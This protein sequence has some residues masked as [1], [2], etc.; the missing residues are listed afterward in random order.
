MIVTL[1]ARGACVSTGDAVTRVP[2]FQVTPVDTTAAGDVFNGALAVALS[3]GQPLL[4]AVRFASAA[5][6]L[7]VTKL[8]ANRPP[9]SA[10]TSPP[11]WRERCEESGERRSLPRRTDPHTAVSR[12]NRRIRVACFSS[13]AQPVRHDHLIRRAGTLSL[14]AARWPCDA[15][16]SCQSVIS[17]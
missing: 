7:S 16:R 6:A 4:E 17:C 12:H 10:A 5:A 14:A 9:R 11:C 8:G 3:E 1:G 2:A 13:R 15:T